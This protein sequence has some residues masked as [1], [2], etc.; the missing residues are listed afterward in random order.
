MGFFDRISTGWELAKESL[1][2]VWGDKKLML[3]PVLS[4][5]SCMA[6]IALI[7]MGV[8]PEN[9][10]ALF[11]G[12]EESSSMEAGESTASTAAVI[13][14]LLIYFTLTF[15]TVFFNVALVGAAR[16]SLEGGDSKV[17]DGLKV[18]MSHLPSII[19]WA[20]ITGTVGLLLSALENE[21]KTGRFI[22]AILG[23]AWSIITYFVIPVMV[24][25]R[26]GAFAAIGRS[27]ATMKRAWGESLAASFSIGWLIF[28]L[29][30]P[31]VLL[32][33]LVG[34]AGSGPLAAAVMALAAVWFLVT[35]ILGQAAKSVLTL[36]LYQY[37]N[38]GTA[39]EG[40]SQGHLDNAF[41]RRY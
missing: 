12:M 16:I 23:A 24:V 13:A 40:Y 20:A 1:R 35:I 28:L 27:T 41:G 8:G 32:I 4:G 26:V 10:Q 7:V 38:S 39:P 19:A 33:I 3:F 25:E 34:Q 36:A 9:L 15:I 37:A 17:S 5:L 29:N 22:R 30:I 2:I 11:E 21:K 18:A 6:F 31:S 14:C